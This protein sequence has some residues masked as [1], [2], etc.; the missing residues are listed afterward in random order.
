[1]NVEMNERIA[2]MLAN[3]KSIRK[4]DNRPCARCFIPRDAHTGAYDGANV[5]YYV[6]D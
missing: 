6:E 5:F 2:F 1:M 4:N 3:D